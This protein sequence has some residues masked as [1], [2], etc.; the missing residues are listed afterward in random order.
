MKKLLIL[1]A[2]LVFP[3]LAF[4]QSCLINGITFSDQDDVDNFP[5][6]YPNC[7]EIEGTVDISNNVI[8]L[9][10]LNAITSIGGWLR[11]KYTDSLA[12]LD[13]L[14][15]LT[16]IGGELLMESNDV[17]AS[18]EGLSGLN[19]VGGQVYIKNNDVLPTL[20]GLENL[21]SIGGRL[22]IVSCNILGDI[23]ALGGVTNIG[24]GIVINSNDS[25]TTLSGLENITTV[26]EYLDIIGN[27]GLLNL[28]GLENIETLQG[29]LLI[30]ENDNMLDL[31]GL[32][33]LSLIASDLIISFN[34]SLYSLNGL[35]NLLTPSILNLTII[36]NPSLS[37]CEA[38]GICN[39]LASPNG[40]VVIYGNAEGCNSPPEIANACGYP[41]PCLPFGNYYLRNQADVDDFPLDY[42]GC[43]SLNGVLTILGDDITNLYGLSSITSVSGAL[44]IGNNFG[45][46]PVL[47]DM[48]GLLN[49]EYCGGLMSIR[50]NA[51]L[52]S[53]AGLD[54]IDASS[55]TFLY[56]R[57]NDSLSNCAVESICDRLAQPG[58]VINISNNSDGCNSRAEV[59]TACMYLSIESPGKPLEFSISP[60]PASDQISIETSTN[61]FNSQLSIFNSQGREIIRRQVTEP[62]TVLDISHL[63]GG[64]YI[65]RLTGEKA[66]GISKF[67]KIK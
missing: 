38:E 14:E 55:V 25:L 47:T 59:D 10:G 44:Y 32:N 13:G 45:G 39:Y 36:N 51:V 33:A 27:N 46:N 37:V 29:R 65:V 30:S 22:S 19:S 40:E 41:L 57:D 35:D 53:L 18:I 31:S 1:V 20:N 11:I 7:T 12:S 24:A 8:N 56:I 28:S 9:D 60:N 62:K 3:F 23:T 21:N 17:L 6:Q 15:N 48:S 26:T 43:T 49:L 50:S 66:V 64:I 52:T 58:G 61:Q 34:D 54:N 4:S 16:T 5:I 63:P 2:G 42:P 67:V